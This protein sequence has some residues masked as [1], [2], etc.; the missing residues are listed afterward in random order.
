MNETGIQRIT[1]SADAQWRPLNWMQN[2]ADVGVDFADADLLQ[3]LPLHRVPGRSA[4]TALGF[5]NDEH[6]NNRAFTAKLVSNASWTARPW[7]N[8][9]TTG[10]RRLHQQRERFRA[11]Q[12]QHAASGGA[13]GR[14]GR[15]EERLGRPADARSR[16]SASTSQEQAGIRDRMFL[17]A[18]VRSD[19][20][21]AFGTNFQRVFYPKAS[22]SWIMSDEA[23][24]PKWSF[25]NPFRLRSAY[26]QSGVQPGSTDALR[27]FSATTVATSRT[28]TRQV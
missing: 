21:S 1:G 23:F 5:V 3:P 7:L 26:G 16:R 27:T 9:K 14:R 11:R 10:R 25:V 13:D 6:D 2:Q 19:Q 15:R 18:A 8:L 12:R 28:S 24:F 4:P 17:T 20:N 22:L